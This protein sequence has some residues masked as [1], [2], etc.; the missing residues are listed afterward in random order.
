MDLALIALK[1]TRDLQRFLK[2]V[3]DYDTAHHFPHIY[4]SPDTPEYYANEAFHLRML[5]TKNRLLELRRQL[6]RENVQLDHSHA[7][8]DISTVAVE[9]TQALLN[10]TPKNVPQYH[11]R[12]ATLYEMKKNENAQRDFSYSLYAQHEKH[13]E[14]YIGII[15]S[16]YADRP[17]LTPFRS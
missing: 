14:E 5:T 2:S 10:I 15:N 16:M 11:Q 13:Y 17:K 6:D 4:E 12:V 1:N 8:W 7:R 9:K 3:E